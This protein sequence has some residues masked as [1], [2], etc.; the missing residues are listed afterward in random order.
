MYWQNELTGKMKDIVR[1][2][3]VHEILNPSELKTLKWYIIQWIDNIK[4]TTI[5]LKN[6]VNQELI[7][8]INKSCELSKRVITLSQNEITDYIVNELLDF[9]IDPF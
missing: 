9:G 8:Y 6:E 5:E 4:L 3:L 2:F 1:K 7:D